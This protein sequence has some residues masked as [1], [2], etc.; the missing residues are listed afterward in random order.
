[1]RILV[2]SSALIALAKI[3]ELDM[4]KIMHIEPDKTILEGKV[5]RRVRLAPVLFFVG[6]KNTRKGWKRK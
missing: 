6:I 2:D 4:L 5:L 1:M 3:G